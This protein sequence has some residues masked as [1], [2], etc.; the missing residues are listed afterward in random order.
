[1]LHGLL[2]YV[3]GVALIVAPF[4]L[5][6]E[7]APATAV[8]I[9]AGLAVLVLAA[10]TAVPTGIVKQVP[11]PVHVAIDF[12]L[13]PVLIAAPFLFGFSDE[14]APTATFIGLGVFHLLLTI[15]TRFAPEE[16]PAEAA[17]SRDGGAPP[18]EGAGPKEGTG[19]KE[20]GGRRRGRAPPPSES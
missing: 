15:G 9:I 14:V 1:M 2:E 19:P 16:K 20:R 7:A 10:V 6:F 11:I 3:I 5:A 17:A 18:R 12:L 4:A 8:S 13:V